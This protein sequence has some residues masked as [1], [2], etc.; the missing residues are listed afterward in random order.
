MIK[1]YNEKNA[2]LAKGQC[3]G[4]PK[5]A[6]RKTVFRLNRTLC[7]TLGVKKHDRVEVIHDEEAGEWYLA[8]SDNGLRLSNAGTQGTQF[9]SMILRAAI[10][11]YL[12]EP[13]GLTCHMTVATIPNT[14]DGLECFAILGLQQP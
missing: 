1:R 3:I 6:V 5:L 11:D 14:L 9:T 10:D 13:E 8:K 4:K 7:E 12:P 2:R